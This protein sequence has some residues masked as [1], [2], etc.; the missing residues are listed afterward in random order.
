MIQYAWSLNDSEC[1]ANLYSNA[2]YRDWHHILNSW[3]ILAN[4]Q[5]KLKDCHKRQLI[6]KRDGPETFCLSLKIHEM[7]IGAFGLKILLISP[8]SCNG[9]CLDGTVSSESIKNRFNSFF[10]V[11]HVY[12]MTIHFYN[13]QV[14][15][16]LLCAEP[17]YY[18]KT[19]VFMW[20][21]KID[22]FIYF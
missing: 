18:C 20:F 13:L 22:G 12:I 16:I 7:H 11:L 10:K 8:V 4:L 5:Q 14:P 21:S 2:K 1:Q 15:T 9:V 3:E 19:T 17:I 6:E